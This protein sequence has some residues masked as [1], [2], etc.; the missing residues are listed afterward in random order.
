M[1]QT[2]RATENFNT[3]YSESKTT[4]TLSE[5]ET[6]PSHIGAK[7][8][9]QLLNVMDEENDVP[10]GT[11]QPRDTERIADRSRQ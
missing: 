3:E 6:C 8:E 7:P 11:S 9:R 2:R 10:G 5:R 1:P 4:R